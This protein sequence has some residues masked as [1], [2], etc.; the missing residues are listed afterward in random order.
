MITQEQ[1]TTADAKATAA[2]SRK[3]DIEADLAQDPHSPRLARQLAEAAQ[4]AAL[5]ARAATFLHREYAEQAQALQEDR[6]EMERA[7]AVPIEEAGKE[8]AA[9][10]E[11][12]VRAVEA[13]QKALVQL[14][15]TATAHSGLIGHHSVV[16]QGH[17]LTADPGVPDAATFVFPG[18]LRVSKRFWKPLDA[19][20]LATWLLHRVAEARLPRHHRL[21]GALAYAPGT[22][23]VRQRAD[24]LLDVLQEPAKQKQQEPAWQAAR[25]VGRA[26]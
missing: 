12:L 18:G 5:A 25:V 24:G 14:M 7:A 6:A 16:L 10:Q 8:L 11:R 17:G 19:G 26:K 3:A 23:A 13:A 20:D 22:L 15:D 9:S 21:V 2:A 1:L 4:E